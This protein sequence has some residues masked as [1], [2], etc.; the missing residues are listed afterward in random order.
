MGVM[1]SLGKRPSR[2]HCSMM[3]MRFSSMNLRVLSR[4]NR[5]SSESRESKSMKSTFL[6]LKGGMKKLCDVIR[7]ADG[8]VILEVRITKTHDGIKGQ[9]VPLPAARF[10]GS[11]A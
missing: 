5:S 6:N 7:L 3:G 4:T 2:L 10:E 9:G 1:S 11:P 8:L